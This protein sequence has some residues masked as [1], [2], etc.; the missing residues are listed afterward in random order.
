[1]AIS[2]I[3]IV[4][5]ETISGNQFNANRFVEEGSSTFLYGTPTQIAAGDGGWQAWAGTAATNGGTFISGISYEAAHGYTG[6]GVAPLPFQPVVTVGSTTT[7]GSVQNQ[8]SAVNIPHGAPF[9]DGR[10][11]VWLPSLDT[12]FVAMFGNNGNTATPAITD[13]GAS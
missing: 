6:I 1:M 3:P 4:P 11:G 5:V 8:S 10:I 7:F 9:T 13:I 12:V 2:A